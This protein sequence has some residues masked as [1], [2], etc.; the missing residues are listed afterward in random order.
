[1]DLVELV[2]VLLLAG[3]A[4]RG[5]HEPGPKVVHRAT[6]HGRGRPRR[7]APPHNHHHAWVHAAIHLLEC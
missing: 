3:L 5:S 4:G 1:M 2:H 7:H 6:H